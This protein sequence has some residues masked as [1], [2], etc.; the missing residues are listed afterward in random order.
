MNDRRRLA[1]RMFL[2]QDGAQLA[3]FNTADI[4]DQLG[5]RWSAVVRVHDGRLDLAGMVVDGLSAAVGDVGLAGDLA[6]AA[7]QSR[8]GV[9]DPGGEGCRVNGLGPSECG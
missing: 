8:G 3:M 2:G 4:L 5:A 7:G 1:L 6:R 9:G